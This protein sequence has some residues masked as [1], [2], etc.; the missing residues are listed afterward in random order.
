MK[1]AG[2]RRRRFPELQRRLVI[3]WSEVSNTAATPFSEPESR[4]RCVKPDFDRWLRSRWHQQHEVH[5]EQ[6]THHRHVERRDRRDGSVA[7]VF[8]SRWDGAAMSKVPEQLRNR[9]GIAI[10]D[11]TYKAA[12][13]L[14]SSPRWHRVFSAGAWPGQLGKRS[15]RR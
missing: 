10:A 11:R 13:G 2:R 4:Y 5:D 7:S 6:C 12:R 3:C 1:A 14:L 15:A 9:L 8:I